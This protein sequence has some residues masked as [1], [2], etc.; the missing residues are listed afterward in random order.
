MHDSNLI[1]S[2][3]N[4]FD[5]SIRFIR[6]SNRTIGTLFGPRN[7]AGSIASFAK[8]YLRFGVQMNKSTPKQWFQAKKGTY[9]WFGG[10]MD[11][12]NTYAWSNELRIL[13]QLSKKVPT[14]V[15]AFWLTVR[16]TVFEVKVEV[17]D[18]VWWTFFSYNDSAWSEVCV[19][20]WWV[21]NYSV[22]VRYKGLCAEC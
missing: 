15:A 11:L 7:R 20:Y 1:L 12:I 18:D 21:L 17:L 4:Y 13:F 3:L 19:A 14:K 2:V 22:N 6:T 16:W 9:G 8:S 5:K 10:L